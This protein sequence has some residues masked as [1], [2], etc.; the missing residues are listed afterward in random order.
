MRLRLAGGCGEQTP[1]NMVEEPPKLLLEL[2]WLGEKFKRSPATG[3][4]KMDVIREGHVTR[5]EIP[6]V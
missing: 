2:T 1:R 3:C 6:R 5:E 4:S